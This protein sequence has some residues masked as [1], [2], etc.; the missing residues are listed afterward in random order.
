MITEDVKKSITILKNDGVVA[1]PTETVYGLAGNA[2][3]EK[4]VR[5]IFDLKRRPEYNPLIVHIDSIDKLKIIAKEIPKAAIDLANEFWPGPLTLI[6]KKQ[7]CIPDLVTSGKDTVAVRMPNHPLTLQLLKQLEFPL[8][9]PSANPFSEIS[10]TSAS[11]VHKYFQDK[12]EIIL[13]GGDCEK[14]LESTIVG[15]ENGV[16]IVYRLGAL[17]I[18]KIQKSVGEIKLNNSI[19]KIAEVKSPGM[20]TRH[21]SP[22][23]KIILS[24]N[25]DSIIGEHQGKKL[26]LLLFNKNTSFN[27]ST[28]KIC[29]SE[30]GDLEEAARN[31]YSALHQLDSLNLD[32]LIAEHFPDE[33]LGKAINDRLKRAVSK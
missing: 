1:I 20:L 12:I 17:C 6:L 21:Y 30:S 29:L 16:P 11:H 26:G 27:N 18:S 7:D 2:F 23:T 13:D 3:S 19:S 14:G 31:L 25:L 15:F 10:P 24:D 9:A 22:K 32:L 4:A 28:I 8:A 33:G 5:R